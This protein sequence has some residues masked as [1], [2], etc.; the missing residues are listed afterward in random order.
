MF[1]REF[2]TKSADET[3]KFGE[4]FASEIEQGDVLLLYGELGAGKTTLTRGICRAFGVNIVKSPSFVIVNI[5]DG[6]FTIYHIDLY[7]VK[8]L[9]PDTAGEIM[10]Y[11]WSGDGISIVEWADRLTNEVVPKNAM[12]IYIGRVS[13]NERKIVIEAENEKH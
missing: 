3:E 5:Y 2:F 13:E 1:R 7:R 12:K 11:L 8:E 9:D 4:K 10:E 6:N